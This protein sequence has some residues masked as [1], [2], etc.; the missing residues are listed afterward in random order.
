[1]PEPVVEI[2]IPADRIHSWRSPFV[3]MIVGF[4]LPVLLNAKAALG[5]STCHARLPV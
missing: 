5:T 2:A 1:M 4:S 3:S